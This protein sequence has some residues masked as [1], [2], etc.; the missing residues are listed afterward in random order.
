VPQRSAAT[1]SICFGFT[2]NS[3]SQPT[4]YRCHVALP[5]ECEEGFRNANALLATDFRRPRFAISHASYKG[6]LEILVAAMHVLGNLAIF[7]FGCG[8]RCNCSHH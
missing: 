7:E 1:A 4:H 5:S 2:L 3:L 6:N 8:D